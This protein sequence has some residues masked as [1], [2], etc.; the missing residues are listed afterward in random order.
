[1]TQ[2]ELEGLLNDSLKYGEYMK[3]YLFNHHKQEFDIESEIRSE[4]VK[5]QNDN[6]FCS[7]N[8]RRTLEE[9]HWQ[10]FFRNLKDD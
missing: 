3:P 9:V 5:F 7:V 1:M 6:M 10:R 8:A 2:D 4:F